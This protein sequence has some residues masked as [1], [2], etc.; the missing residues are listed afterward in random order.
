MTTAKYAKTQGFIVICDDSVV[1][2]D[3]YANVVAFA[4][5]HLDNITPLCASEL[6]LFRKLLCDDDASLA[7]V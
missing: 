4:F 2:D 1:V 3:H 5:D 6:A 7:I